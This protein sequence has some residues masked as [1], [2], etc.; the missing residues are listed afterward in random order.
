MTA[1]GGECVVYHP[2]LHNVQL[3]MSNQS[4][5]HLQVV[6]S[7]QGR[8]LQ[9]RVA[10]VLKNSSAYQCKSLANGATRPLDVGFVLEVT[11][12]SMGKV[13]TKEKM[14]FV[15]AFFRT[16]EQEKQQT[17]EAVEKA[18]LC[19]GC[20]FLFSYGCRVHVR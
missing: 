18:S 12:Q 3:S 10:D 5:C 4:A 16:D 20:F 7:V 1:M 17:I 6:L 19:Y 13:L 2:I 15:E 11:N 14:G 9:E 8:R